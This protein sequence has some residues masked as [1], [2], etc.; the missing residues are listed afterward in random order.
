MRRFQ[1]LLSILTLNHYKKDFVQKVI[2][3][4][5]VSDSM[6]ALQKARQ[7]GAICMTDSYAECDGIK[8]SASFK[9]AAASSGK[10]RA[11]VIATSETELRRSWWNILYW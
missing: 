4:L 5:N 10:K 2:L 8:I 6:T 7:S 1:V 9:Q 3:Q 11:K